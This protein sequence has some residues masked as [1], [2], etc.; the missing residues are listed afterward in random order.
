MA[1]VASSVNSNQKKR[2]HRRHTP[3]VVSIARDYADVN[4]KQPREYWDY[5]KYVCDWNK[6]L[7]NYT[8]MRKIGR[9]KY[10]EVFEGFDTDKNRSICIKVLKPVKK[11]KIKREIKILE[12]LKNGTNI[13]ELYDIVLDPLSG[14]PSLIFEYVDNI[15]F[16]TLY[17]TFSDND[18]RYYMYE[19]LKAID[20]C[21]SK[22]IMHRDIKP[23]NVMIDAKQRKLRLIDWGLSEFYH[24][25]QTYNTRTAARYFK[26]KLYM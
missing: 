9:G 2:L 22:G 14:I 25:K 23:H 17:E 11:I 1:T 24:P 4:S 16:K 13:I 20:Y 5:E 3:S 18:V 10:S 12:T 15:N 26:G 8:L 21:H 6:S 19:L 7:D